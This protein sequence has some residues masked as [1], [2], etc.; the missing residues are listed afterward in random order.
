MS[1]SILMVDDERE[2]VKVVRAYLE[3]NGFRVATAFD[4]QEALNVF[5]REKPDSATCATRS[6]RTP[7]GLNTS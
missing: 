2:I 5:R 3:Q 7:S 6:S 1:A 4:G